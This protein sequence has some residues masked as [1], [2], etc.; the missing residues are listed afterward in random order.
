MITISYKSYCKSLF[1]AVALLLCCSCS[2]GKGAGD[3]EQ[4][5]ADNHTEAESDNVEI[6]QRQIETVGI[7]LGHIERKQLSD[8]I[9]ATGE[10]AV[11]PQDEAVASPLLPGIVT[12]ICVRQGDY[13]RKGAP[14]AYIENTEIVSLQQDYLTAVDEKSLI[15]QEYNRQKALAEQGAGV[16]KNYEQSQTS[17]KVATTRCEGL[18][19]R[20]TQ[21]GISPQQVEA[22]NIST[23]TAV[24]ADISGVVSDVMV[25]TGSFADMQT[26]VV[27][28]IDNSAVYCNL[29]IFEKDLPF[30]SIGQSAEIS[31]TNRPGSLF[32]GKIADVT[33]AIDPATKSL[34]VR[35]SISDPAAEMLPGMAVTAIINTS[36]EEVDALPDDAVVTS[37]GKSYIFVLEDRH[38]EN[39]ETACHFKRT[40]VITGAHEH[41]YTQIK[42]LS[43]IEAN[44]IV[45]TSN[46][47][48]LNSMSSDHGEHSH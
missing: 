13:V 6:T 14:V 21:L 34:P 30:I 24:R 35:V 37:G 47:F 23:V 25:K 8:V 32:M 18:A 42:P 11:N 43:P 15:E 17:L 38:E 46:A 29:R 45:V 27:S 26:P 31:L 9:H 19:R 39:G 28:I 22:G 48:Y 10:L 36:D 20:L 41:G 3:S 4:T 40:E 5:A 7:T 2:G 12:R 33:R 44:A 16:R 1:A